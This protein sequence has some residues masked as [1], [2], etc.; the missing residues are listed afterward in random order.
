VQASSGQLPTGP[1]KTERR[2]SDALDGTTAQKIKARFPDRHEFG[3]H[4]VCACVCVRVH[5]RMTAAVNV[6]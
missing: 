3:E 6:R 5:A 4:R 2:T 1:S